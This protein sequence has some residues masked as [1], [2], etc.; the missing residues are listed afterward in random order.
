MRGARVKLFD[1]R[2]FYWDAMNDKENTNEEVAFR[3]AAPRLKLAIDGMFMGLN[4][5][6]AITLLDLSRN[7]AKVAFAE[8]PREKAGFLSWMEFET[9]GD[10]MWREGLYVGLKFDR[11]ISERCLASTRE[12]VGDGD[13]YRHEQLLKQ[14]R[15]WVQG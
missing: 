10:V 5:R 12:R 14:A 11:P 7:G 6:Q 4:G 15:E 9:F 13:A 1:R 3:R 8:P 2:F